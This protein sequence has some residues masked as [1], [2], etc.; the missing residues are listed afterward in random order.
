[1]QG[2]RNMKFALLGTL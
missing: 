2:T 1:M